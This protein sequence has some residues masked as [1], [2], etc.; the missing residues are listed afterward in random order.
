MLWFVYENILINLIL[1]NLSP[2]MFSILDNEATAM[3]PTLLPGGYPE[4]YVANLTL[5]SSKLAVCNNFNVSFIISE[6]GGYITSAQR[7][8]TFDNCFTTLAK[9][10][11]VNMFSS[12]TKLKLHLGRVL[13]LFSPT[14]VQSSHKFHYSV[15]IS[16]SINVFAF[17]FRSSTLL[18]TFGNVTS[19]HFGSYVHTYLP[20]V[21]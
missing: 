8:I 7:L 10:N 3:C 16:T 18:A 20:L 5:A 1:L 13:S 9:L 11:V 14:F 21:A 17:V 12:Q 15:V 19:H 6:C 2:L 4:D